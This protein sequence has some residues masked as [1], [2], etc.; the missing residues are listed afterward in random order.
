MRPK[1]EIY[2]PI[3]KQDDKHPCPFLCPPGHEIVITFFHNCCLIIHS[4]STSQSLKHKTGFFFQ[5]EKQL[6][7][8]GE[9]Q[10][11][12]FTLTQSY[13]RAT[14]NDHLSVDDSLINSP[15]NNKGVE[16]QQRYVLAICQTVRLPGTRFLKVLKTLRARKAN[17][18]NANSLF[19][20]GDLLTYFQ[21]NKKKNDCEV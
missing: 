2:T 6:I 18:E 10:K 1:S 15:H 9:F 5:R 16:K 12:G 13:S 21:G 19:W 20:K 11:C 17:C 3:A 4:D 8:N 14:S 7:V